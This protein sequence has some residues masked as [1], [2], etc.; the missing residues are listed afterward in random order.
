MPKRRMQRHPVSQPFD[1]SYRIIPLTRKQNA[2]VDATDFDWLNQW[3]WHARWDNH[4]HSF[5]AGRTVAD[6]SIPG[7]PRWTSIRMHRI[8]LNCGSDEDCDHRNHDTL[9]NR[10]KNLRKCVATQNAHNR[11]IQS[12]NTS[13]FK[14]V[15][16]TKT[17][18]RWR[19]GIT[20]NHQKKHLGYFHSPEAAARA[21]DA[22][23]KIHHGE[24]AVLNFPPTSQYTVSGIEK[25]FQDPGDPSGR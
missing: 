16:W 12:T 19:A 2:I 21:Y 7:T 4:T 8:I 22:A 1:S 15:T 9:D 25:D 14:G 18:S 3:N 6:Y 24:F 17:T 13:G 20:V 23:A 11:K 10:K 5:Y